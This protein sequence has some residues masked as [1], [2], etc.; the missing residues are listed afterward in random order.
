MPVR[1]LNHLNRQLGLRPT[2][3]LPEAERDATESSHQQRIREYLG[4][5]TFDDETGVCLTS[6]NE[7][8]ETYPMS[9][10]RKINLDKVQ[11]SLD[12]V[13]PKCGKAISP[14]EIRRV[15]FERIECP[16]CGERFALCP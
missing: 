9:R 14:A 4:Y 11:A 6:T 8:N 7:T 3:S 1:I 15:D 5:R 12:V 16:A 13:C 2:V 10:S